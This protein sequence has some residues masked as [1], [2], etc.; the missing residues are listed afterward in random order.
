MN[1]LYWKREHQIAFLAATAV[2]AGIGI[3]A[4]VRQV[5]PSADLYW[6]SVGLWGL[7]GAAMGATGAFIR[8]LMRNRITN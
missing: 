4:G 6:L 1:P 7:V 3:L 2:C 8:Q 5:E